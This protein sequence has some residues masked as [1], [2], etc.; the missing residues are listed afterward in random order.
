[1]VSGTCRRKVPV[2]GSGCLLCMLGILMHER[3]G[4][5]VGGSEMMSMVL[6]T[7]QSPQR[8]SKKYFKRD[9]LAAIESTGAEGE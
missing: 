2:N 4:I 7:C 8:R 1:M 6:R 9:D 5:R 3:K